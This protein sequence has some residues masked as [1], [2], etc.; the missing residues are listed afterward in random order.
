MIFKESGNALL[1]WLITCDFFSKYN[2]TG[3]FKQSEIGN[4][5]AANFQKKV[6]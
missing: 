1:L 4:Q 5:L 6:E 2:R 3:V